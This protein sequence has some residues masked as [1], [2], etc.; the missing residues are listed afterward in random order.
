[1]SSPASAA[2]GEAREGDPELFRPLETKASL[3]DIIAALG[4]LPLRRGVYPWAGR[5]PDPRAAPAGD[6]SV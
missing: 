6:D 4:P 3:R 1:M 2:E 5:R